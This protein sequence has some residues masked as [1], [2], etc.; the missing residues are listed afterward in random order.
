MTRHTP[1]AV[2]DSLQQAERVLFITGAGLSADSGLPTY[3]GTG[4]LYNDADTADGVPI[5]VALSGEM[6]ARHPE[7]TWKYLAQIEHNCRGAVPN[8]GHEV[9]AAIERHVRHALVFTQNIDGFHARAGSRNVIEIHGNLYALQ[10]TRCSHAQQ[11]ES[12]GEIAIPPICPRCGS[13][14]RPRV[15]LF[16][17]RLDVELIA[18]LEFEM[19][20]GFDL[21]FSVGTS[22]VFPY[23]VEPVLWAAEAGIPT[24]E[25]NPGNTA[26]SE[27]VDCH[28]RMG[29]ADAMTAIWSALP[30]RSP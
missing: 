2:A 22:S 5:E 10:C 23:I 26:I 25:I 18:R 11:V 17:E 3:R 21:V 30:E 12:Y 7:I 4:G 13:L 8:P 24:V 1:Q 20:S 19:N 6:L 28:L 9:I 29:A 27:I 14:V 16:G 15:V